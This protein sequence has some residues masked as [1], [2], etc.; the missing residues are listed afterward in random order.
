[1]QTQAQDI[2]RGGITELDKPPPSIWDANHYRIVPVMGPNGVVDAFHFALERNGNGTYRNQQR[3][4]A[5]VE[6]VNG[7]VQ[8][9]RYGRLTGHV[10]YEA[11]CDGTAKSRVG[12][13]MI[14]VH[15]LH[16]DADGS[17]FWKAWQAH[18][19]AQLAGKPIRASKPVLGED[20]R[21]PIVDEFGAGFFHPESTR[22]RNTMLM[23]GAHSV[24]ADAALLEYFG[25][26]N[27]DGE[28]T[29]PADETV[30][31][32]PRTRPAGDEI[33]PRTKRS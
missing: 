22:R 32:Q 29:P 6:Y 30:M 31:P 17:R 20:G 11:V 12:G 5:P 8:L 3:G 19:K 4:L 33:A 26:P 23:G 9:T 7:E 2:F 27:P 25:E 28:Y 15:K 18:V 21:T 24:D 16:P 1:M 14:P 13:K 10:F